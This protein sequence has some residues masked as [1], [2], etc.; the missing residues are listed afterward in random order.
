MLTCRPTAANRPEPHGTPLT[1]HLEVLIASYLDSAL[2]DAIAN[3][4]QRIRVAYAPHLLPQPQWASDHVGKARALTSSEDREWTALL[5]KAEVMF[6]FDWRRPSETLTQSPRLRWIQATSAG[7]G[8]RMESLGLRGT[9]LLVTTASGVH[10]DPL[11]EFA[12]AGI[13]YF[14]RGLPQ[15]GRNRIDRSWRKGAATELAGR[16]AVIVGAGH[17]GTRIAELLSVFGVSS[18]GVA[19]RPRSAHQPYE[20]V[21]PREELSK[22]LPRADILVIA[23]PLTGETEAMLGEHEIEALPPGAIVVNVGRGPTIDEDALVHALRERRL[24][25]AVLDVTRIEPLPQDSP[26]WTLDNVILSP[27]A[28]ANVPSENAKITEIFIDN[29]RRYLSGQTMRNVYDHD[30]GY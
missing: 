3:A 30:A 24:E 6:D 21:V 8:T 22:Y 27:H 29:L 12:I 9:P 28:A 2:V 19:R 18:T 5:A 1:S 4:D 17:I 20:K 25:G 11:A 23:A 7:V 15:L 14:A 16:H 26:L 10:V 13:L